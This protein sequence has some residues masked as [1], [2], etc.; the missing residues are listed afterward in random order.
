MS[1]ESGKFVTSATD[2]LFHTRATRSCHAFV[3]VCVSV[4]ELPSLLMLPSAAATAATAAAATVAT[5][6]V[7]R[8]F[9][10]KIILKFCA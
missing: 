8:A 6:K 2:I 3:C 1:V 7:S 4:C 9:L 5:K 10:V